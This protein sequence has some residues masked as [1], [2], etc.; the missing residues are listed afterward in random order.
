MVDLLQFAMYKQELLSQGHATPSTAT[1][2]QI[3]KVKVEAAPSG[4]ALMATPFPSANHVRG[5]CYAFL[6]LAAG[7]LTELSHHVPAT[8]VNVFYAGDV[9]VGSD[10]CHPCIPCA[11]VLG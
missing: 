1:V 8:I 3:P 6:K 2:V 5:E 9:L 4:A 10:Y 11:M 7:K